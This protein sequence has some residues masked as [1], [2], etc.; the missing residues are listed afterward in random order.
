MWMISLSGGAPVQV[1]NVEPQTEWASSWSPDG[2]RVA[3]FGLNAGKSSLM[4]VKPAETPHLLSSKAT[5]RMTFPL[6]LLL[7]IG[8]PTKTTK[9]GIWFPPTAKPHVSLARSTPVTSP[10]PR[11]ANSSTASRPGRPRRTAT[12]LHSSLSTPPPFRKS[13][14]RNL[15]RTCA[16]PLTSVPAFAS[17]SL[18]TGRASSTAPRR[19]EMTSGCSRATASPAGSAS[20]SPL[21]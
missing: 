8:S 4:T 15:A 16:P 12:R 10:S 11:T 1:T 3:Y 2:S 14:S 18:L 19:A 17:A 20:S 9:A 21:A 6:D 7:E 13:S 5:S